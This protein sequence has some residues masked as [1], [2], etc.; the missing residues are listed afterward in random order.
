MGAKIA[1]LRTLSLLLLMGWSVP[2]AAQGFGDFVFDTIPYEVVGAFGENNERDVNA[3]SCDLVLGCFDQQGRACVG[4]EADP[5]NPNAPDQACD[6][7][8]VPAGRCT[9][10]NRNENVWPSRSG[11]RAG[12][13]GYF[14]RGAEGPGNIQEN[15]VGGVACMT[16]T[17][18]AALAEF[19]DA[20]SVPAR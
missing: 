18:R 16:D 11:E 3:E 10:G 12:T 6:L 5:N 13:L 8:T 1:A 14:E 19:I 7:Q 20:R 15:A 2:A 17:Y 9:S 4:D